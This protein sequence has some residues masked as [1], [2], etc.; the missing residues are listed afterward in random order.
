MLS[1]LFTVT[2]NTVL[3]NLIAIEVNP[4]AHLS[5]TAGEQS[6]DLLV[7][8]SQRIPLYLFIFFLCV[9]LFIYTF[10]LFFSFL[11]L[12]SSCSCNVTTKPFTSMGRTN[13]LFLFIHLLLF[14][15]S[16]EIV[17]PIV[18]FS[19]HCDYL[20]PYFLW[21]MITCHLSSPESR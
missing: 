5:A 7:Y 18:M 1:S 16:R 17:S 8:M 19:L 14:S 2:S 9:D 21:F 11:F 6:I 4:V 3:E 12:S 20:H 15:L 10:Y 13:V